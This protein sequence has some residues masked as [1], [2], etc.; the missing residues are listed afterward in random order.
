M[1]QYVTF[2]L[3]LAAAFAWRSASASGADSDPSGPPDS[4]RTT[5]SSSSDRVAQRWIAGQNYVLLVPPVKTHVAPGFI[6][7]IEIFSYSC[8]ICY[9]FEPHLQQW[10][11]AKPPYIEFKRMPVGWTSDTLPYARLYDTLELLGRTDLDAKVFGLAHR[12]PTALV[13]AGSEGDT[14]ARQARFAEQ[15]GIDEKRFSDVYHSQA[16]SN[17][18]ERADR[19]SRR[20]LADGTPTIVING[21]YVT[22]VMRTGWDPKHEAVDYN[23]LLAITADLAAMEE[24]AQSTPRP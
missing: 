17:N 20:Y 8:H 21:K 6:E 1:R 22:N 23:R 19:M 5:V 16:V 18:L 9:E 11:K 13:S 15:N 14:F 3:A 10:L 7:V 24:A 2:Y 12:D 4:A